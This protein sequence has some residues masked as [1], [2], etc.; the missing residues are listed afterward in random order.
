V[1]ISR[2]QLW[3]INVVLSSCA[4]LVF[5]AGVIV[6]GFSKYSIPLFCFTASVFCVNFMTY[7]AE[8]KKGE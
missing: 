2:K 1:K 3:L 6:E 5:L 4:M 8:K 7:S